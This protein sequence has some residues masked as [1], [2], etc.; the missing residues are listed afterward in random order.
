MCLCYRREWLPDRNIYLKKE[1]DLCPWPS[2]NSFFLFSTQR[3][4]IV[5]KHIIAVQIHILLSVCVLIKA[6]H[7]AHWL[8]IGGHNNQAKIKGSLALGLA[9]LHGKALCPGESWCWWRGGGAGGKGEKDRNR[10]DV[11]VGHSC[12]EESQYLFPSKWNGSKG[13]FWTSLEAA[14]TLM[15]ALTVA[16]LN[17]TFDKRVPIHTF[18]KIAQEPQDTI[19]LDV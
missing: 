17:S 7:H 16:P 18:G 9:I 3:A 12:S 13:A 14:K 2:F 1:I 10:M 6:T 15:R 4:I 11:T 8:E 5:S 19:C